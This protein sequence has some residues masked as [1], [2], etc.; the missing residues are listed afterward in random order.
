MADR[1]YPL[2]VDIAAELRTEFAHLNSNTQWLLAR[3]CEKAEETGYRA[4][5]IRGVVDGRHY[6]RTDAKERQAK[7]DK[8]ST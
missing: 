7:G 6:E 3:L 5:Y 1:I 4:G 2:N 8:E